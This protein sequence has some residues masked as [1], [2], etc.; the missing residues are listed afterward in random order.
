MPTVTLERWELAIAILVGTQRTAAMIDVPDA[1]HYQ[2]HE[3][4]HQENYTLDQVGAIAE[5]ATAKYTGRYWSPAAWQAE[6]H[7]TMKH[8]YPDVMPNIEVRSVRQPHYRLVVRQADV[9]GGRRIVKSQVHDTNGATVVTLYGWA[10]AQY[11]WDN[12]VTS[13]WGDENVRLL[14]EQH[15]SDMIHLRCN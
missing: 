10:D 4:H 9:D 7:S 12:G 15:L 14:D 1:L 13:P 11:A 5:M 3:K 2:G 8:A 6:E